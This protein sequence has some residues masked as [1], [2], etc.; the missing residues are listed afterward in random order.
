MSDP[1]Q[2]S[3][4]APDD[5][6][7]RLGL[8]GPAGTGSAVPP[9]AGGLVPPPV[10]GA[11]AV[12]PPNLGFNKPLD[13]A[14]PAF[15]LQQQQPKKKKAP[16]TNELAKEA[17]AKDTLVETEPVVD[18]ES[19][20]KRSRIIKIGLFIAIPVLII[21]FVVGK[22]SHDRSFRSHSVEDAAG[23]L[24]KLQK[25]GPVL[26]DVA[27]KTDGAIKRADSNE[28]DEEYLDWAAKVAEERPFTTGD[29]DSKNYAV[30]DPATV[31]K[32]Y[33]LGRLVDRVFSDITQ[34]E[35]YTRLDLGA[36][37]NAGFMGERP[38]QVLFGA[39]LINLYED[40]YAANIGVI[41]NPAEDSDR[42]KTLDVQAKAG[43]AADQLKLYTKGSFGEKASDWVTPLDPDLTAPGAPLY[44]ADDSHW[45][46]YHNRLD[47]IATQTK[48]ALKLHGEVVSELQAIV[49]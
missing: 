48:R 29:L 23:I 34:H 43:R 31:D 49:D 45:T 10:L 24:A 21:G 1:K 22:T 12:P 19:V 11:P 32:L 5:L 20:K 35:N 41:S 18:P 27:A 2:P 14:P 47:K 38:D 3:N 36:L 4:K 37:K 8:G 26:Q 44:G 46:A 9:P 39:V 40:V 30:F 17:F 6:R 42:N 15:V 25:A 28:A 16:R 33:D 13:V 7:Q